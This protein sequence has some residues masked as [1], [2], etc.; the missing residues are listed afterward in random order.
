MQSSKRIRSAQPDINELMDPD[1]QELTRKAVKDTQKTGD[2]FIRAIT[3][4]KDDI[5]RRVKR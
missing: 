5:H 3:K 4:T 2:E 1:L